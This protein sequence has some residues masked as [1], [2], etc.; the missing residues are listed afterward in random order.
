MNADT[1]NKKWRDAHKEIGNVSTVAIAVSYCI[2]HDW[3]I[4]CWSLQVE[5]PKMQ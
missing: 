4:R 2:A 1:I 3:L 5:T